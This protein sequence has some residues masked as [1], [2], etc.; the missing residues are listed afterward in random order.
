MSLL[1]KAKSTP[2]V[3]SSTDN[4]P[5]SRMYSGIPRVVHERNT[6][7]SIVLKKFLRAA[8]DNVDMALEHFTQALK[9]RK[10]NDP[11][12]KLTKMFDPKKFG[13][14]G[15]VSRHRTDEGGGRVVIL[16]NLY[17]VI[18]DGQATFGDIAEFLDFRIALMELAVRELDLSNAPAPMPEIGPDPYRII[19]VHDCAGSNPFTVYPKIKDAIAETIDIFQA[20]YPELLA[21]HHFV[22]LGHVNT[23]RIKLL[24]TLV[25]ELLRPKLLSLGRVEFKSSLKRKDVL[26]K[27]FPDP[28]DRQ[29]YGFSLPTE[30][31]GNTSS[32]HDGRTVQF[33]HT[34]TSD[35]NIAE[36]DVKSVRVVV[37]PARK[38][39]Q[40]EAKELT[41][42]PATA[43]ASDS[44]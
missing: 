18:R 40:A 19:Q 38:G 25:P 24:N 44:P 41:V 22:R 8:D 21:Y 26:L 14:M 10:H 42:H 43:V 36:E 6:T 12:G 7:A 32:V 2:Q 39:A 5:L 34:E 1:R 37:P 35:E 16:W 11:S 15:F 9:W 20:N 27:L 33:L 30:F 3:V 28:A 31:G 13:E 4:S 23:F 29:R 17:G